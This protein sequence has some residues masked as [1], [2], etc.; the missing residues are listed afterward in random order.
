MQALANACAPQ[1]GAKVMRMM[2]HASHSFDHRVWRAAMACSV[3]C[4]RVIIVFGGLQWH[5]V[6]S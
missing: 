6:S 2:L 1:W 5:A 4:I 3:Q